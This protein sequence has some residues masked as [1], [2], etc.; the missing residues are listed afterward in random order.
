[1]GNVKQSR[2]IIG[3]LWMVASGLCFIGVYI[4]VRYV[5]TRLPAAESA[6]LRYFLGLIFLVP[7]LPAAFKETI[8]RS[9]Y[10]AYALRGI[11]HTLAVTLWFFSMARLPVAEVSA[12]GYLSPVFVTLIAAVALGEKLAM[13]RMLAI[14]A[15]IVGVLIILRPGFREISLGH[16][17]MI[18]T[19]FGFGISYVLAKR[20]TGQASS[21]MIVIML[22]VTVTIG[23]APLAWAV[24]VPPTMTEVWLL[25]MVGG[26]A[27]AGHIAMTNAFRAAPISITQPVGFLQL[28]WAV[29][30]GYLLFG[31]GIDGFV[32]GGGALIVLAVLYIT[33]REAQLNRADAKLVQKS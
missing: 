1:M 27:T 4:G 7:M 2:P 20:L 6:F 31:E 26:F 32:I 16:L 19:T 8:P 12:M 21:T 9:E 5:G 3:A 28:V 14:A 24:W 22:S 11:V 17:S 33:L 15:A 18:G 29:L 25:L 23:L 10:G 13:R 30:T